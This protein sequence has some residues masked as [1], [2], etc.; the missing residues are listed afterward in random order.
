MYVLFFY[1]FGVHLWRYFHFHVPIM[2]PLFILSQYLLITLVHSQESVQT[3]LLTIQCLGN[4]TTRLSADEGLSWTQPWT[5]TIAHS[6]RQH[7][8]ANPTADTIIESTCACDDDSAGGFIATIQYQGLNYGTTNPLKDSY[9]TLLSSSDGL[10]SPLVYIEINDSEHR[11]DANLSSGFASGACWVWNNQTSNTMVFQFDFGVI[12]QV[13]S[14]TIWSETPMNLTSL[15]PT[16]SPTGPPTFPLTSISTTSEWTDSPFCDPIRIEIKGFNGLS[17]HKI[18][19]LMLYD[20]ITNLTH[21]AIFESA[22]KY[23]IHSGSFRVDFGSAFGKLSI[24]ETLCVVNKE[25]LTVLSIVLQNERDAINRKFADRLV[26]LFG[27][28]PDGNGARTM[29]RD[30]LQSCSD[31][32]Q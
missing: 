12:P 25:T 14:T 3:A 17:S 10:I 6:P 7:E 24:V 19:N 30:S 26:S 28:G 29:T 27:N 18:S 16:G 11:I 32:T 23:G 31:D 1:W 21:C 4:T 8:I 15:S 2:Y 9:W 20:D 5:E 22:S 13:N